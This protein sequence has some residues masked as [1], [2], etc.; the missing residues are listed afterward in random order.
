[1]NDVDIR[2]QVIAALTE[3]A[4]EIESETLV[5]GLS[6]RDQYPFD[7]VEFLNFVLKLESALGLSIPQADYPQLSSLRGCLN[8]F[9][10]RLS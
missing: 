3:V 7:S 9:G 6:F 1:M 4:P 5:P 8:Y 10:S 2:T